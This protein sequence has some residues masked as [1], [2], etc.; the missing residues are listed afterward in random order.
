MPREVQVCDA[1]IK[2]A[3]PKLRPLVNARDEE[4]RIGVRGKFRELLDFYMEEYEQQPFAQPDFHQYLEDGKPL[5]TVELWRKWLRNHTRPK[6]LS[7]VSRF[8]RQ[9]GHSELSPF[10]ATSAMELWATTEPERIRHLICEKL[11]VPSDTA[12]SAMPPAI[13]AR[14]IVLKREFAMLP[15]GEQDA[16]RNLSRER[17]EASD[18]EAMEVIAVQER[19]E[20][21]SNEIHQFIKK[22]MQGASDAHLG[23]YATAGPRWPD[24]AIYKEQVAPHWVKFVN[25]L[26]DDMVIW[27]LEE[28][29]DSDVGNKLL[30]RREELKAY[31]ED[32]FRLYCDFKTLDVERF[33]ADVAEN[34]HDYVD[35]GRLPRGTR[36]VNPLN[37]REQEFREVYK[38]VYL[39]HTDHKSVDRELRFVYETDIVNLHVAEVQAQQLKV[40]LKK[41]RKLAGSSTPSTPAAASASN[42]ATGQQLGATSTASSASTG[43]SLVDG[44]GTLVSSEAAVPVDGA[45]SSG[46]VPGPATPAIVTDGDV[47]PATQTAAL[48]TAPGTGAQPPPTAAAVPTPGTNDAT[49]GANSVTTDTTSPRAPDPVSKSARKGRGAT[50]A[51]NTGKGATKAANTG[52]GDSPVTKAPPRRPAKPAQSEQ[53]AYHTQRR[54]HQDEDASERPEKAAKASKEQDVAAAAASNP[55][56]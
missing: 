21:F 28:L 44:A 30:A 32:L 36:F 23:H 7:A 52:K 46:T 50:K 40:K 53:T 20:A 17:K 34:P 33:W 35:P 56:E 26:A 10:C 39:C 19:Q 12:P 22:H 2:W 27:D 15:Q 42:N 13:G 18:S 54:K 24:T 9:G 6:C 49:P 8:E 48:S 5:E 25:S 55:T 3:L 16:W 38:H 51:A 43:D 14:K 4:A 31:F 41:K 37:M 45:G 29:K 11:G 47:M 1:Y